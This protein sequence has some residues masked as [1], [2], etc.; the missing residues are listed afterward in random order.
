MQVHTE[1][2]LYLIDQ[3]PA[4]LVPPSNIFTAEFSLPASTNIH[5]FDLV[6]GIN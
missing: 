5:A 6:T 3:L 2:I 1:S 4:Y